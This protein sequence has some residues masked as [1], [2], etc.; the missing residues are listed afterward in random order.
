MAGTGEIGNATEKHKI[1]CAGKTKFNRHFGEVCARVRRCVN[2]MG[3]IYYE[4]KFEEKK[5]NETEQK[6]AKTTENDPKIE[7]TLNY[8]TNW[9]TWVSDGVVSVPILYYHCVNVSATHCVP[10][11]PSD[12]LEVDVDTLDRILIFVLPHPHNS[13]PVNNA[14]RKCLQDHKT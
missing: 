13:T 2:A 5:N 12:S 3:P 4:I 1:I 7:M 9:S 10:L 6:K 14:M 11:S 8:N